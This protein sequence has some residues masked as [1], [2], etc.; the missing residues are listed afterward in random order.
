MSAPIRVLVV[1]DDRPQLRMLEIGLRQEGYEV[2][3]VTDG[4]EALRWFHHNGADL[5]IL[6]LMLPEMNGWDVCRRIREVSSVPIIMLTARGDVGDRIYGLQLGADDYL[7]KPFSIQEL[8]LRVAAIL[9]RAA[10]TNKQTDGRQTYTYDDGRLQIDLQKR[11][12]QVDGRPV[13]L[14]PHE[15]D[16]LA[17]FVRHADEVLPREYLLSQVWRL[18]DRRRGI[19]YVKTYIR[20]LREKLEVDPSH[21]RYILTERGVGYRLVSHPQHTAASQD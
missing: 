7:S 4:R 6:D 5:I 13:R 12:V 2:T 10:L 3:G 21:P 15:Y 1:E 8:L 20:Y 14:S 16:L 19:D 17:C 11:L 18:T 9:R